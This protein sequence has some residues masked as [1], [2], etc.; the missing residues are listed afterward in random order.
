LVDLVLLIEQSSLD[1]VR[2]RN[3]I[4]DTFQRRKTHEIPHALAPPPASWSGPFAEL[5]QECNLNPEI[6]KQFS[7][8]EQF[9]RTL[10]L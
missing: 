10:A 5:A 9:Y 2:L 1:V 6:D 3:A 8:V 7:K 4:R